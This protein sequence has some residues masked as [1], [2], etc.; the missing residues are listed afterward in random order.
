ML[1]LLSGFLVPL[2][3]IFFLVPLQLAS[4]GSRRPTIV[5]AGD[6]KQLGPIVRSP[7][8]LDWKFDRSMME[9]LV[10]SGAGTT[11]TVLKLVRSYRAHPG[12]TKVLAPLRKSL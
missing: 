8:A 10:E 2:L 1:L 12:L 5:L 7:V 3:T 9:R 4:F 6:H 11:V